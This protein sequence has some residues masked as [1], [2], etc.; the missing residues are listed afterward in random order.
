V[1]TDVEIVEHRHDLGGAAESVVDDIL[2]H[3]RI[4]VDAVSGATNSSSVIKKAVENAL[5]G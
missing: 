1:I 2:I 3:Q 4:D 5:R